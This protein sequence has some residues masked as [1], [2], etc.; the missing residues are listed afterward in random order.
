MPRS[1]VV[2]NGCCASFWSSPIITYSFVYICLHVFGSCPPFD[3]FKEQFYRFMQLL[4]ISSIIVASKWCVLFFSQRYFGLRSEI[5]WYA[6]SLRYIYQSDTFVAREST[7]DFG[8]AVVVDL[9]DVAMFKVPQ[10]QWCPSGSALAIFHFVLT[11]SSA[12]HSVP[13]PG[14]IY[15][16]INSFRWLHIHLPSRDISPSKRNTSDRAS[17]VYFGVCCALLFS[18]CTTPMFSSVLS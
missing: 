18:H 6:V 17:S 5:T 15:I 3:I 2:G 12:M 14:L 11:L 8:F 16:F 1:K 13:F 9:H 10:I 7:S 4:W